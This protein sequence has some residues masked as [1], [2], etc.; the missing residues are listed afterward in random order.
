MCFGL[1]L[2]PVGFTTQTDPIAGPNVRQMPWQAFEMAAVK[3][4]K[5]YI[6]SCVFE[7]HNT[8]LVPLQRLVHALLPLPALINGVNLCMRSP[9]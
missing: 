4:I 7:A 2:L 8:A 6:S 3:M 1:C 5:S 9:V